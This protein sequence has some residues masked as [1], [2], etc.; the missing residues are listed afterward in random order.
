MAKNK[1]KAKA[2]FPAAPRGI[3]E[4]VSRFDY[5]SLAK[6]LN[7]KEKRFEVREGA[8][9]RAQAKLAQERAELVEGRQR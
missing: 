9:E 2:G 8:C 3:A 5:A 1:R 6:I 4:E 7:A